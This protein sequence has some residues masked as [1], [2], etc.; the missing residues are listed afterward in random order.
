MSRHRFRKR[1]PHLMTDFVHFII[2][3]F[4]PESCGDGGGG[5]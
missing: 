3:H 4:F 5:D 1:N 2:T